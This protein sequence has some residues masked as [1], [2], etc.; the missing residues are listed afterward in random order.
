MLCALPIKVS[1][2]LRLQAL[3]KKVS[4]R[5]DDGGWGKGVGDGEVWLGGGGGWGGGGGGVNREIIS[6]F[7]VADVRMQLCNPIRTTPS[8]K[9]DSRE[10]RVLFAQ[11]VP[12]TPGF[13]YV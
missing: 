13:K 5:W 2:N 7:S 11:S 10:I 3:R 8:L 4:K 12:S 1:R 6:S 9:T